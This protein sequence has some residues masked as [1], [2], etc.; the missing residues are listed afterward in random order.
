MLK[1]ALLNHTG[2]FYSVI[3]S[4]L[5]K[6]V[7]IGFYSLPKNQYHWLILW[8]QALIYEKNVKIHPQTDPYYFLV[9]IFYFFVAATEFR[10][11]IDPNGR[12]AESP[13]AHCAPDLSRTPK[14]NLRR[15]VIILRTPSPEL[16]AV[17]QN[18]IQRQM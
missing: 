4:Y 11:T 7:V 6:S 13:T 8:T 12:L 10:L 14:K 1:D 9:D 3:F 2:H 18:L 17:W 16:K 5:P 15:R